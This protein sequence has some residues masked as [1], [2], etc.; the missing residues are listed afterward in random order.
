MKLATAYTC[1][2]AA[3]FA[4]TLAST[5][6]ARP[7]PAQEATQTTQIPAAGA[8]TSIDDMPVLLICTMTALLNREQKLLVSLANRGGQW[9]TSGWRKARLT[10]DD[11]CMHDDSLE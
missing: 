2:V 10:I 11:G 7:M 9:P 4:M 1:I 8:I 6:S 3:L 5:A